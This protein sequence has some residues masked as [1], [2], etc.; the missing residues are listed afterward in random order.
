MAPNPDL[1]RFKEV[2]QKLAQLRDDQARI[3]AE[4]KPLKHER[5]ELMKRLGKVKKAKEP[6][7]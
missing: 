1:K 3:T 2:S 7:E 5:D 6:A 4:R